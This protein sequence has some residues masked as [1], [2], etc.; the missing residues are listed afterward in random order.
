MNM[1]TK[2]LALVLMGLVL[3][4]QPIF[5]ESGIP[6]KVD[7]WS[8]NQHHNISV[9]GGSRFVV[10]ANLKKL[11]TETGNYKPLEL[12]YLNFYLYHSDDAGNNGALVY[13]ERQLTGLLICEYTTSFIL[14]W[15]DY[16]FVVTY[17]GNGRDHLD[18]SNA[19]L[20]IHAG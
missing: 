17:D 16:N 3:S 5:A 7:V 2:Y 12:R 9:P 20:K 13:Q 1:N 14:G 4:M 19:T 15:G 11:D 18:P 6:T 10:T 8:G